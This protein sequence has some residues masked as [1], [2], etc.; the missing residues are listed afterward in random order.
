MKNN[1]NIKLSGDIIG[2]DLGMSRT[3]VARLNTIARIAEPLDVIEMT[4][5]TF[6]EDVVKIIDKY[7]AYCVVVGLPRGLNGQDTEQTKWARNKTRQLKEKLKVPTY[8]IDEAGTTKQ[9]EQIIK[10]GQNV[11]SVA[12]GILLEDFV[13]EV[14]EGR[15]QNVSI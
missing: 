2:L 11:D 13:N 14:L 5:D 9:A 4:E 8:S 10:P 7:G 6:V 12:A 1:K 3:G 15:I